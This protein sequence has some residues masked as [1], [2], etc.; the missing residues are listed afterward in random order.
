M[1]PPANVPMRSVGPTLGRNRSL[2]PRAAAK[3]RRSPLEE[4]QM[5][6]GKQ[7]DSSPNTEERLCVWRSRQPLQGTN[8]SSCGR[9]FLPSQ[10]LPET[11]HHHHHNHYHTWSQA[12]NI[13]RKEA[14][15]RHF[16][17]KNILFSLRFID[18]LSRHLLFALFSSSCTP[19][20]HSLTPSR[21]RS[22]KLH[23][24]CGNVSQQ[25]SKASAIPPADGTTPAVSWSA[26][27]LPSLL[28]TLKH[29]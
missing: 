13:N 23:S 14:E 2:R 27:L 3:L 5:E 24:R 29:Q 10:P 20:S 26:G 25:V 9:K 7:F 12:R 11:P 16:V 28:L 22:A 6:N 8:A 21:Y 19:P 15:E 17:R 4:T 18:T 1:P